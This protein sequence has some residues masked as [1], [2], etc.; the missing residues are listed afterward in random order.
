M[1][2]DRTR[3]RAQ[4]RIP[5]DAFVV[6]HLGRLAPEK[7]LEFL[8]EAVA[9]FLNVH[10]RA[11]FLVV[12]T[13]PSEQTIRQIF[14]RQGLDTRL[15]IA[16]T[17][18]S[19][20]LAGALHAMD[21][22]AFSSKSETQGMVL[23]EAMAAGLPVVALDAAGVREVV[24]DRHNGRLLQEATIEAFTAGVQWIADQPAERLQALKHSAL[25]T[26]ETFSLSNTADKGLSC[27]QALLQS[28]IPSVSAAEDER[29]HYVLELIKAEWDILKGI[30][31]AADAAL[32][33]DEDPTRISR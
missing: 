6:G 2:G 7:N 26:A 17:L 27:Y 8:A 22:F 29:W 11:C 16:G 1:A 3:F 14:S 31:G 9:A 28:R 5:E 13:G 15:H 30:A 19:T 24:K 23:T 10:S 25:E 4:L 12:G 33:E 18:E 20:Q 32:G 21:L